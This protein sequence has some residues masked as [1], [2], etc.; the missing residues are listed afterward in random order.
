MVKQDLITA[1]EFAKLSRTTKR[2]VLFY[3]LKKILQPVFID[4]QNNYRYYHSQQIIDFQTILLLRQ[5]GFSLSE[6]KNSLKKTDSLEKLFQNKKQLLNIEVKKLLQQIKS[7]DIYYHNL[8]QI[9]LLVNPICKNLS[10]TKAIMM[11]IEGSYY[12]IPIFFKEFINYFTRLNINPI[13]IILFKHFLFEPKKAQMKIGVIWHQKQK[14]KK[15]FQKKLEITYLPATKIISFTEYIPSNCVSF[16]WRQMEKYLNLKNIKLKHDY[17]YQ[18][19]E[20]YYGTT[21][22]V[23]LAIPIIK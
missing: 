21:S 15:D 11:S 12:Q 20:F 14:I 17:P 5:L 7:T 1:G 4:P 18:Q 6:I 22:K 8:H 19:L 10:K 23:E 2:T 13:F 9:G 16:F 3:D